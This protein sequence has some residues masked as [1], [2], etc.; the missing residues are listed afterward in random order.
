MEREFQTNT[1]HLLLDPVQDE[2]TWEQILYETYYEG[3]C[4]FFH[5]RV[6]DHDVEDL[7]HNVFIRAFLARREHRGPSRNSSGWLYRIA[8]NVCIDYY[9]RR[10]R[11]KDLLPLDVYVAEAEEIDSPEMQLLKQMDISLVYTLLQNLTPEQQQVIVYRFLEGQKITVTGELMGK[12]EGAIKVLQHR[13]IAAL[14]S[15]M[16]RHG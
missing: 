12:T 16:E 1:D 13:A 14:K 6:P 11:Q 3:L 15:L 8:H 2:R 7:T 9:R 5:H 10:D 4:R